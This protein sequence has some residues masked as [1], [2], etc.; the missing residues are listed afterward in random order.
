MT[1]ILNRKKVGLPSKI[2]NLE[3]VNRDFLAYF[4]IRDI[5][6]EN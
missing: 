4:D 6:E 3:I 2:N 1:S 5:V